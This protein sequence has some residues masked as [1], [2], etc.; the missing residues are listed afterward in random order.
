MNLQQ[1]NKQTRIQ[2]IDAL[3]GLT[4]ILV[5]ICHVAADLFGIRG[6][7]DGSIHSLIKQF[8]MPMFFFVSGFVLY[9]ENFIYNIKNILSFL[10]R[11]ISIQIIAPLIFIII[12][13]YVKERS[14]YDSLFSTFKA[15][16]WFPFTLF[17]FFFMYMTLK[18]VMNIKRMI[19]YNLQDIILFIIGVI[20][21]FSTLRLILEKCHVSTQ[22][23]ELF[24]VEQTKYFIYFIL[25]NLVRKHFSTFIFYLNKDTFL[26]ICI[27]L[28]FVINI[29]GYTIDNI[30]SFTESGEKIYVRIKDILLGFTGI[31][32]LF[33][34]FYK[35]EN[36]FINDTKTAKSLKFIGK[37]TLDIYF[38]H[39]FFLYP[40]MKFILPYFK[41]YNI[42]LFE[43]VFSI[44]CSGVIIIACLSI[45][46]ILRL[47][48]VIGHFLFGAK[49]ENK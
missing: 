31:I 5:V 39:Y 9:K 26:F 32:L 40:D 23:I 28:F 43:F 17:Q 38:I 10:K 27:A 1:T 49:I 34:I 12:Y 44:I 3:R 14:L 19:P 4:M 13:T 41:D 45:G 8:R 30:L 37:R 16:Y 18:F 20:L 7:E 48:P 46:Y 42:P 2:Y 36:Y 47:S 15:G 25:G 35:N 21:Y 6:V 11:K 22:Y 24:G 33:T 29:F